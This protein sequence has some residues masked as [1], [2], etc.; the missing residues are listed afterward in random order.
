MD[1]PPAHAEALLDQAT[2]EVVGEQSE[3]GIDI[4][5]DGEIRRES[6]SSRFATSLEGVDPDR[7]G[8][9]QRGDG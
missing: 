2:R 5:T 8:Q 7:P 3:V 1:L 9:I 4:P 6:Y